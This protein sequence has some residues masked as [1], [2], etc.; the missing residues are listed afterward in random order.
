MKRFLLILIT[1]I[2]LTPAALAE[3]KDEPTAE[4]L[5]ELQEFKVKYLTQEMDLP[6][7]K[8]SEFTK[9]YMQYEN[10]RSALFRDLHKRFRSMCKIQTPSDAEYMSA[11]ESMS[12]AKA[13]E[14]E[15]EKKYFNKFKII[16]TPKQLYNMKR[17]E[18]KF[19]RKLD[20]M[21][22]KGNGKSKK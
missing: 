17:A 4:M 2:S 10:E 14:G 8:Q 1:L 7:D 5:K 18:G 9:L 22:R 11:A 12:T 13:R 16:L 3:P 19:D 6:A 20:E 15:L 21:R